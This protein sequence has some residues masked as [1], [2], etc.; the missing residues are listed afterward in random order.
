MKVSLNWIKEFTDVKLPLEELVSKIGAQLGAVENVT[1]LS[2]KYKGIVIAGVVKCEPHP[3]AD[4]L[5]VCTIDDSGNTPSVN[6]EADGYVKV[7]CGAPNVKEG[8]LVAWLP[9]GTIVPATFD[10]DPFVLEA[11]DIRGVISNGMLASARELELSD[12]HEGILELSFGEVGSD[13]AKEFGL[14]DYIIDIENKMFTHRPDLFGILGVA[15]EIAG[16]TGQQ[17]KNPE[18]Y[19]EEP[20]SMAIESS[21]DLSVDNQISELVPRF[22]AR[23]IEGVEVKPSPA[24]MQA[25]LSRVGIR[26]INNVVDVTNYAMYLTAQPMHAYDYDKVKALSGSGKVSLTVRHSRTGEKITLLNGKTIE[27]DEKAMMVAVGDHLICFGGAVGSTNTEVDENTHSVIMEAAN[28][29][30]YTIRRSSMAH[31]IFTDAV[32]RFTKGQSP[33]QN[34][35]VL[36]KATGWVTHLAGGK[37]GKTIDEHNNLKQHD[38]VQVNEGFVSKRLGVK[39]DVQVIKGLLVNVNFEVEATGTDLSIKPPFWRTDIEIPEDIVEEV[40]RLYGYDHLPLELPKRDLTPVKRDN[41]LELKTT[42]R[43]MLAKAGANE[44]LTYS[45]IHGNLID[46][47]GQDHEKAFKLSN[48]LSPDLQYYRMSLVPSL[49]DKVHPNIKAGFSQFA[50]FEIGKTHVKGIDD[51]EKLPMEHERLA[52]V[53]AADDKQMQFSG[54]AYYVAKKYLTSLL[55]KLG[56]AYSIEPVDF[57]LT[58]LVDQIATSPY[59]K[60]R[61]ACIR[62]E[63]SIAGFV[64]ELSSSV[65]KQLKLPAFTAS[66]EVDLMRLLRNMPDIGNNYKPISRYPKVQQDISL[67]VPVSTK[68]ANLLTVLNQQLLGKP[69][70]VATLKPL[71]IFQRDNNKHKQ[72][73][74]RFT[75]AHY[76]KTLT[77]DEVNTMLNDAAEVANKEFGAERI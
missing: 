55:S 60:N 39:L 52:L 48:A 26:P 17:F 32:T 28:W 50:L 54:A 25:Y 31:G 18:W 9:P 68:Y 70:V 59:D 44:L 6:R 67:K 33:L 75:I 46:K 27:P 56:V 2:P 15:R 42:I 3:N 21:L 64:G 11:R 13:F 76:N 22:M 77:A 23:V 37:P 8:M 45:F 65:R 34:A 62:I 5:K 61:L 51:S 71:D 20:E 19:V 35:A 10:K 40:G 41:L 43:Q 4:K 38:A 12:E 36:Q 7:V 72:I 63:G 29:D 53:F 73:T 69:D 1:D 58:S 24:W 49:L 74:F 16:I 14:D 66:F 57:E 47:V 30:M